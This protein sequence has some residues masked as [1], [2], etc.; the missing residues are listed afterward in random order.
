MIA[1]PTENGSESEASTS[2]RLIGA[3]IETSID[4]MT[5]SGIATGGDISLS[6]PSP[7]W[8]TIEDLL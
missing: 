7:G 1:I 3:I 4:R 6:E 2:F 5:D 8:E